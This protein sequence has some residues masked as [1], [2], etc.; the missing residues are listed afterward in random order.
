[1]CFCGS[2]GC[3]SSENVLPRTHAF[4]FPIRKRMFLSEYIAPRRVEEKGDGL[5]FLIDV[6]DA[7]EGA[8]EGG[9]LAEGYEEGF[10][11]FSARVDIDAAVEHYEAADT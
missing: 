8:G 5:F 4:A 9:N 7:H 3:Y 2:G 1:M 10:V 6:V 11:Y